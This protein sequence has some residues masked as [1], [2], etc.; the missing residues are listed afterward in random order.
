M[1]KLKLTFLDKATLDRDDLDFSR[2]DALP[3]EINYH[4]F[5]SSDQLIDRIKSCDVIISN[6]VIIDKVALLECKNLKLIC[7]AATGVNNVDLECAKEK[8]IPV[9]NVR[10][11][12]SHS[13]VQ[14]VF[15]L[16][17][18]LMTRLPENSNAVK[19][20]EWQ[21]QKA[22][23]L[24]DYPFVELAGKKLGIVGYGALGK[25][26]ERVAKAFSMEVLISDRPIIVNDA[27]K[28]VS[29]DTAKD[30]AGKEKAKAQTSYFLLQSKSERIPFDQLIREVDVLSLHC[31]LTHKNEK[32]ISADVLSKMK[33]S[34]ILIN[35]ARGGLVD[36]AALAQALLTNRIAGAGLDVLSSEP[37]SVVNPLM[38]LDYPNLI[39]TPHV[40]W[41]ARESRQ[42][43][44]D[45]VSS[46]IQ[47]FLS[48]Q[49]NNQL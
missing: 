15:S 32:L 9:C 22:F 19:N 11:Y 47:S 41:A 17:L 49:L 25:A 26:V 44:L 7:I 14:H 20:G 40:A 13:V 45:Q 6:K 3:V 10:N 12:A 29:T 18:S 43:L 42:R 28:D 39:I 36:E 27:D 5:T 30:A 46:N 8:A 24:L 33:E 37:P 23:C 4:P 38:Q 48:G 31:P 16:I 21:N 1:N 34:A 35:T 2:L